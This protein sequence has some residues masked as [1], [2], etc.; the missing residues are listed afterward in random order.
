[1]RNSLI[2]LFSTLL[3]MSIGS[4]TIYNLLNRKLKNILP[5]MI[6]FIISLCL[7]FV[8][9]NIW[10]FQ[11]KNVRKILVNTN[12]PFFDGVIT[13]STN[14]DFNNINVE[15]KTIKIK[16]GADFRYVQIKLIE[17]K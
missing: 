2:L 1:M 13:D 4:V 11:A 8:S 12:V 17:K 14:N 7:L 16:D 15:Y 5:L 10:T 6:Y 3:V 9:L